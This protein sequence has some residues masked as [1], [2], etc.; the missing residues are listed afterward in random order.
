MRVLVVL[1][2]V[3]AVVLGCQRGFGN[4][5]LS[6]TTGSSSAVYHQLGTVLSPAWAAE[7][8]IPPPALMT[9]AGSGQNLDR[10]LSGQATT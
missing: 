7:L 9:S 1:V 4:L 6:L 10:L 8:G 3:L 2:C 5:R